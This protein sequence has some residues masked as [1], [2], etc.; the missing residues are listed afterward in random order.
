M[1]SL[2]RHVL[3]RVENSFGEPTLLLTVERHCISAVAFMVAGGGF[4]PPNLERFS[5]T[6]SMAPVLAIMRLRHERFGGCHA[7]QAGRFL[8]AAIVIR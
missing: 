5:P 3:G 7:V 2:T 4:E 8:P 1:S 6:A